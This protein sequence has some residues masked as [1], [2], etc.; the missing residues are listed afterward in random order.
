LNAKRK[1]LSL[2]GVHIGSGD[3]FHAWDAHK[4]VE[5]AHGLASYPNEA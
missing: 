4:I 1:S 3:Y 5:Q 2:D